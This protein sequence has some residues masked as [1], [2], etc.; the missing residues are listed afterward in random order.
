MQH[1]RFG[2]TLRDWE[3]GGRVSRRG[4]ILAVIGISLSWAIS[5]YF[6]GF[7]WIIGV[8]GV[9][10]AGLAAWLATRPLPRE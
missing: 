4:K 7:N 2:K 10:L 9:C 3:D 1:R 5:V 6:V 8:I